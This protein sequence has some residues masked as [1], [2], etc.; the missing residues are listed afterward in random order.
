MKSLMISDSHLGIKKGNQFWH[1]VTYDIFVTLC[2][3]A[4]EHNI[5][6]L[7][8]L[9]DFFDDRKNINVSTLM[10]ANRIGKMINDVFDD[11]IIL[12]GNH[13]QYYKNF[14]KPSSLEVLERFNNIHIVY[15]TE[16]IRGMLFVPWIFDPEILENPKV[17]VCMG[18]FEMGGF[19]PGLDSTLTINKFKSFDKVFTGH[20]HTPYEKENIKYLG[21][22]NHLSFN[23]IGDRGF[24]VY[25]EDNGDIE[26]VPLNDTPKFITLRHDDN[27]DEVDISGN[28]VRIFFTEDLGTL[29]TTKIVEHL[30][31]KN[32]YQL[33]TK[34]KIDNVFTEDVSDDTLKVSN[35]KDL[36]IEFI[37][38]SD[39]PKNIKENVLLKMMDNLWSEII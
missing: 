37:K 29:E 36:H 6:S 4:K 33:F 32:P 2:K 7:I 19:V 22:P 9:G 28:I 31:S 8:Y 34:F 3:Y 17:P 10:Y 39:L 12:E 26:F 24:Y 14:S 11:I 16:S 35:N 23:D 1:N 27:F 25:D 20:Y 15:E 38:K 18:H 21:S 13:D 5:S 30:K